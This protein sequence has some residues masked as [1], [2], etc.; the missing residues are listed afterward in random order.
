[1]L[2]ALLLF[3]FITKTIKVHCQRSSIEKRAI[4]ARNSDIEQNERL[5][6]DNVK[7]EL[8]N[9]TEINIIEKQK[10]QKN[11]KSITSKDENFYKVNI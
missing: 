4:S 7:D 9:T 5:K 3:C 8:M 2:K 1:M 11:K 10:Q 6:E